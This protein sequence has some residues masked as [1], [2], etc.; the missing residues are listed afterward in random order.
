MLNNFNLITIFHRYL[1]NILLIGMRQ[2]LQRDLQTLSFDLPLNE[3]KKVG[4]N[5][6]LVYLGIQLNAGTKI[7]N[8]TQQV[9][10]RLFHLINQ[11]GDD[12]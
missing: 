10:D 6:Q 11:K 4:P 1:D 3:L 9:K 7:V 8:M 2:Q 5:T 12:N